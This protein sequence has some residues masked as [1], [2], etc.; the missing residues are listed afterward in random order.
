MSA[1]PGRELCSQ[2][3]IDERPIPAVQRRLSVRSGDLGCCRPERGKEPRLD[4]RSR[5][6][7]EARRRNSEIRNAGRGCGAEAGG[8]RA[9]VR[10]RR[11]MQASIETVKPTE[12]D[13]QAVISFSL[14]AFNE[15]VVGSQ[16]YR[17]LLYSHPRCGERNRCW[18]TMGGISQ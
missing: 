7:S 8:A 16:G 3:L 12:A 2:S 9:V 14:V 17:A 11:S 18:R 13:R 1:N 15:S 6:T 5:A 4:E 10:T